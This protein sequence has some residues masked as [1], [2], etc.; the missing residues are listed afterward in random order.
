MISFTCVHNIIWHLN[1]KN[2]FLKSVS[3][4]TPS[5]ICNLKG[6]HYPNYVAYI[7][8]PLFVCVCV[9]SS[10]FILLLTSLK[11][12]VYHVLSYIPFHSYDMFSLYVPMLSNLMVFWS[13]F[14]Y[15]VYLF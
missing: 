11:C 14:T 6:F 12:F 3:H 10:M 9:T 2:G 7:F 15:C 8:F 4:V 13:D 1:I 5:I